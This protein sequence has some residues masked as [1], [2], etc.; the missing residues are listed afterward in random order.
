MKMVTL[1]FSLERSI[2]FIDQTASEPNSYWWYVA[3]VILAIVL[4]L[5]RNSGKR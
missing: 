1:A 4:A 2:H 5:L 3:F